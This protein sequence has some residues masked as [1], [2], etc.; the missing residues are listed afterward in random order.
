VFGEGGGLLECFTISEIQQLAG[1]VLHDALAVAHA[2]GLP[3]EPGEVGP[4]TASS[5]AALAHGCGTSM[6]DDRLGPTSQPPSRARP[7][8]RVRCGCSLIER[9]GPVVTA[10]YPQPALLMTT[11]VFTQLRMPWVLRHLSYRGALGLGGILFGTPALLIALSARPWVLSIVT[12]C[13][14][15]GFGFSPSAAWD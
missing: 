3:L 5:T 9:P 11:T 14:G 7:R 2:E 12:P 8:P 10:R 15:L 6:L 4:I 13:G 1:G